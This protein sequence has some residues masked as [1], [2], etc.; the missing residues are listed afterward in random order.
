MLSS[1]TV[2]LSIEDAP[3][4]A[5]VDIEVQPLPIDT[6]LSEVQFANVMSLS[7]V[8]LFG[9]SILV[10]LLHSLNAPLLIVVRLSGKLTVSMLGQFKNAQLPIES[11]P[12]PKFT[13]FKT[14]QF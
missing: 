8:T 11:K 13:L 12:S 14:T 10:S 1:E 4:N 9:I 6:F 7:S 3:K 5:V 2:I